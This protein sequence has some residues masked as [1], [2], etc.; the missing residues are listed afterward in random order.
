MNNI[1]LWIGIFISLRNYTLFLYFQKLNSPDMK[2]HVGEDH[3]D[4]ISTIS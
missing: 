1:W 4:F 2:F 3:S